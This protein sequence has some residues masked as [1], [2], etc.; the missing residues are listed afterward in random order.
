MG[1]LPNKEWHPLFVTSLKE[2]LSDAGPG[3]VDIQAEVALSSKPLD[4]DVLVVKKSGD[5]RLRH[6][7]AGIFR[8]Y[9]LFEFKSPGDHLGPNDFDKGMA[10]A[11]LYKAIEHR[12]AL[13]LESFT[14]TFA[15]R[16]RPRAMLDMIRKRGLAVLENKPAPGFYRIEG[17]P[18]PIQAVVLKELQNAEES[19]MF[20]TFMTGSE[21]IRVAATALL[22]KK[23]L[24]DPANPHRREL[25]EFK[26]RNQLVTPEEMEEVLKMRSQ[27]AEKN[28]AQMEAFLRNHPA[29]QEMNERIIVESEARGEARGEIKAKRDA[30][31]KYLTRKFGT[32]STG[33]QEKIQQ[34]TKLEVLD[35]TLDRLFTADTFEEARAII[36]DENGKPVQ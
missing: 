1:G 7:L 35:R 19:Y 10:I 2:A 34:V 3:E 8:T 29:I 20:S 11:Y 30:I 16:R 25:L 5:A 14:V 23:H 32:K 28:R 18:M 13:T 36:L 27:M 4:I 21:K 31:C 26:F 12:K 17:G 24:E 9:N 15:S 33:L 22:L 6:P